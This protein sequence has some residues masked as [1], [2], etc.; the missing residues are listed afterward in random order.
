MEVGKS[1]RRSILSISLSVCVWWRQSFDSHVARKGLSIIETDTNDLSE[2]MQ[3]H[4]HTCLSGKNST[5]FSSPES[6]IDF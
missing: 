4:H 5:I 3:R 2:G 6:G 1:A